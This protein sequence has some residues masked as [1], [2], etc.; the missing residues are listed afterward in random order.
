VSISFAGT[1]RIIPIEDLRWSYSYEPTHWFT[2][3][4]V[5]V[6]AELWPNLEGRSAMFNFRPLSVV[7][8]EDKGAVHLVSM[9]TSAG[10][11][12]PFPPWLIQVE[13]THGKETLVCNSPVLFFPIEPFDPAKVLRINEEAFWLKPDDA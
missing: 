3:A 13:T 7:A 11:N 1:K 5:H 12:A 8:Q 9:Y 10:V 2:A 6:D 4:K